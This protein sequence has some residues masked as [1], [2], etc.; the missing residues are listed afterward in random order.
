MCIFSKSK[1][2]HHYQSQTHEDATTQSTCFKL[3]CKCGDWREANI[4]GVREKLLVRVSLYSMF[5]A[6]ANVTLST[7]PYSPRSWTNWT[8]KCLPPFQLDGLPSLDLN[9]LSPQ[10]APK[11]PGK[12]RLTLTLFWSEHGVRN[13]CSSNWTEQKAKKKTYANVTS[14][15]CLIL[16]LSTTYWLVTKCICIC[17]HVY[18][19][20]SIWILIYEWNCTYC[21]HIYAFTLSTLPT[22]IA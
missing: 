7:A 18:L 15:F 5:L 6:L 1:I 11:N 14:F 9:V 16:Y 17:T 12:E 2:T 22:R 10:K 20:L 3:R 21:K 8:P 4:S 19:I 13:S